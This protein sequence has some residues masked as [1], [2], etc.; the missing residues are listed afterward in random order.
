[1]SKSRKKL[2]DRVLATTLSMSLA[3]CFTTLSVLA[4][5]EQATVQGEIKDVSEE[6]PAE[7][8][9]EENPQEK[10]APKREEFNI[11]INV[12]EDMKNKVKI[13][14][15]EQE[16]AEITAKPE[17]EIMLDVSVLSDENQLYRIGSVKIGENP[18]FEDDVNGKESYQGKFKL[19]QEMIDTADD[20]GNIEISVEIIQVYKVNFTFDASMGKIVQTDNETQEVGTVIMNQD[21]NYSFTAIPEENYRVA[22]IV[23]DEISETY[24]E[25]SNRVT[26]ELDPNQNH[27]VTVIFALNQY[28]ISVDETPQNGFLKISSD[29]V[30]YK[31]T[32]GVV[33]TPALNYYISNITVNGENVKNFDVNNNILRIDNITED[34]VI[35]VDFVKC[36]DT[37]EEDFSVNLDNLLSVDETEYVFSKGK[38][39]VFTTEKAGIRLIGENKKVLYGDKNTQ[40]ISLDSEATITS[41]ELYYADSEYTKE[42]WHTVSFNKKISFYDGTEPEI[43]LPELPEF[44]NCYKSDVKLSLNIPIPEN[45]P[46]VDKIEYCINDEEYITLEDAEQRKITVSAEDYDRETVTVNVKVTDV[47]GHITEGI[48]KEFTI[49]SVVPTVEVSVDGKLADGAN[50]G[51]YREE[52]TAT[53]TI[54]DWEKTLNEDSDIFKII[55]DNKEL[56]KGEKDNMISWSSDGDVLTAKILFSENGEYDWNILYTNLAGMHNTGVLSEN[57]DS[58]YQFIID[59]NEMPTGKIKADEKVWNTIAEVLSFGIFKKSSIKISI[60]EI[61]DNISGIK[62]VSYFVDLQG[63]NMAD[64]IGEAKTFDSLEALYKAENSPFE[65]YED[66]FEITANAK[67][68]VYARIMDNAGNIIYISSDGL[69]VDNCPP[70]VISIETDNG[71]FNERTGSRIINGEAVFSVSVQDIIPEDK[72]FSGISRVYYVVKK[73]DTQIGKEH[74]LYRWSSETE[75]SLRDNWSGTFIFNPSEYAEYNQDN[76]CIEVIVEDNSGNSYSQDYSLSVNTDKL[77]ASVSFDEKKDVYNNNR[78]SSNYFTS[79]TAIVTISNDR[80]TAFNEESVNDAIIKA[81]SAVD[82]SG[83]PVAEQQEDLITISKWETSADNT[84]TATVEFNYDGNYTWA[85]TVYTNDAGNP[86]SLLDTESLSF[87][88]DSTNPTGTVTVNDNALNSIMNVLTFGWWTSKSYTVSLDYNDEISHVYAYYYISRNGNTLDDKALENLKNTEWKKYSKPVEIKDENA[89]TI[90]FKVIDGAGNYI[91]VSSDE[92][93]IIDKSAPLIDIFAEKAYTELN[94]RIVYNKSYEDGISVTV[95]ANESSPSAGLKL[96]KYWIE[97][98]GKIAEDS[99]V[100]LFEM[101]ENDSLRY[102]LS[103]KKIVIDPKKYNSSNVV[104]KVQ[105]VDNVNNEDTKSLLLDIDTTEPEIS[106][107][108]NNNDD[109][110]GNACFNSKRA[111][112]VIITER[113]NH[114]DETAA[115]KGISITAVDAEGQNVNNAYTISNWITEK[116]STPDEYRHIATITYWKDAEYTFD[117]SYT[118]MAGNKNNG[119]DVG[120]SVAPYSFTID[121]TAPQG[122]LYVK[123]LG[124]RLE[125]WNETINKY[126]SG[127]VDFDIFKKYPLE[128]GIIGVDELSGVKE[129]A[130]L[131]Q[132]YAENL[133]NIKESQLKYDALEEIYHAEES[134]FIELKTGEK[135]KVYPDKKAVVYARIMDN[136]GNITYIGSDGFI[137]DNHE[138]ELISMTSDKEDGKKIQNRPVTFFVEVSDIIAENQAFSGISRIYYNVYDKDN[139]IITDETL[140]QWSESEGKLRDSWSGNFT[141]DAKTAQKY[142]E[143]DLRVV[144]GVVDNAENEYTSDGENISIN[145]DELSANVTFEDT[146]NDNRLKDNHFTS[147]KATVTISNERDTSFDMKAAEQA[148]IDAVSAKAITDDDGNIWTEQPEDLITVKWNDYEENSNVRTAS[149]YFNYCG[150]YIWKNTKYTNIAGNSVNILNVDYL[151]FTIDTVKPTGSITIKENAESTENT[152]DTLLEVLTFGLYSKKQYYISAE[153]DDFTSDTKIEYYINHDNI[154]HN[155]YDFLDSVSE[156]QKYSGEFEIASQDKYVIYLRITDGAGNYI[157]ICSDGHIID[158]KEPDITLSP[159]APAVTI[160]EKPVYNGKYADGVSVTVVATENETYAG[161]KSVEYWVTSDGNE[162]QRETLFSFENSSPEYSE[163]VSN[164]ED[165]IIVDT[166]LNNS[167]DVVLYVKCLDNAGNEKTA[168]IAMDIDMTAPEISVSYDNNQDNNGNTYFDTVRTATVAITERTNHFDTKSATE[169]IKITAVD[170]DGNPVENAFMISEWNTTAGITPDEDIHI[171][172]ISYRADANYTFAISYTDMAHNQNTPTDTGDSVAPYKFTV[173]TT[174]PT[175]TVTAFS[176]EGRELTWDTLADNLKFGFWS[177]T[178]INV[179]GTSADRTSPIASV[180]YYKVSSRNAGDATIPLTESDLNDVKSWQTFDERNGINVQPNEQFV[181]YLKIMDMAGN[182]QYIST[183][184]LIVDSEAPHEEFTAPEINITPEQKESGI[185]NGNVPIE[186]RVE[187]PLTG[188]TYSGLRTISYRVLNMG[189]ETQSGTLYSFENELPLQNELLQTW[190]GEITVDSNLNNSNDVVIEVYAEDNAYNSSSNEISIKIDVT[191]PTIQVSYDNN[192]SNGELFKDY[193]TARIAV[194]ERNFSEEYV[195][196][197]INNQPYN[198]NGWTSSGG[199]GNGDDTIWTAN[200]PFTADGDYTFSINCTDLASNPSSEVDYGVSAYPTEFTI[201]ATK[202]EISVEFIEEE[203]TN[204]DNYYQNPRIAQITIDELHFDNVMATEGVKCSV[205][206]DVHDDS[207][208]TPVV[209]SEWT[210]IPDTNKYVATMQMQ[211]D[212]KYNLDVKYTDMAGNAGDSYQT[213]FY[214]DNTAPELSVSVNDS[215]K[216]GAYSGE[217]KSVIRYDDTNF[218]DEQVEISMSGVNVEVTDCKISDEELIFT[219]KNRAGDSI[220]WKGEFKDVLEE[221]SSKLYG[222]ELTFEN[223]PEGKNLKDFDDIYTLKVSLTDK[224]GRTSTQEL[225]FSVNRFGS[226][227]DITQIKDILGTYSQE[228]PEIIVSEVN[229]DELKEHSVTLFKNNETITLKKDSDYT[230]KINGEANEWH[231]Y[232]YTIPSENFAED[233]IY[234]ITL[235]SVDK[236]D[237]ISE[238]TLDTKDSAISF[239]VDNTPPKAI[240]ANLEDDATYAE[241]SRKIIMTAD[242]NLLLSDVAVYLDNSSEALKKWNEN[243]IAQILR[244]ENAEGKEFDF[245]ISGDSTK[246]HTLKIICTDKAGNETVLEYAGFYITTNMW[247]R[248][249]NNKPLLFGSFAGIL[250]FAGG[251]IFIVTRKRKNS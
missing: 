126:N 106:V 60:D 194:T 216:R 107:S 85:N 91:Y 109:S 137:A 97:V 70:E 188:G 198:A 22:E 7:S 49:N 95:S 113:N 182:T 202:P 78:L 190:T 233:G 47:D 81:I 164:F 84:H 29:V 217:I 144:I 82:K 62:E 238:N 52:R 94:G 98:D 8:E 80:D 20:D 111:A 169:N 206:T 66:T 172:T 6:L 199:A 68:V 45:Y 67:A 155:D 56:T 134:P 209:L 191:A 83:K 44:L 51:C 147:R 140:Y 248:Y 174:K 142:N 79:R 19:T 128:F 234:S 88:I 178:N 17:D 166:E 58:I 189:M 41:I 208:N 46:Q 173:D 63:E 153:A 31:N 16:S 211:E 102:E 76:I 156:W 92:N 86:V 112:T 99:E 197:L 145:V 165:N 35:H 230:V 246:A 162:T 249:I 123:W 203:N 36:S 21:D 71:I 89:Y 104:L 105:A 163:L 43:I 222:R 28:R 1:M 226:T 204:V 228:S 65:V 229:P 64:I 181:I 139:K 24:S 27:N 192:T 2:T 4:E 48:S 53:V 57:G 175:G 154:P 26:K 250:I 251:I 18:L 200:V 242:D 13:L 220:E 184:G 74:E 61:S 221:G 159:E 103:D 131:V 185:Y 160:D 72:A 223:F 108:Y 231:E 235:H 179:S 183:N 54:N 10:P 125:E 75:N 77:T 15:N 215:E 120:K 101:N 40:F 130:Y 39:A 214:V 193:R 195:T 127:F 187:D 14:L 93:L 176:A 3:T 114:F 122:N 100:T 161:L 30:D 167:S 25:N 129:I 224:S 247:I 213:E 121:T 171:A 23:I 11:H 227:Y 150:N 148:I 149:V 50:D 157:Y 151:E 141:L 110:D 55:K 12:S 132:N 136:A 33:I 212:A 90:Y 119:V 243:E 118:D 241:N 168:S 5:T 225:V 177:N 152:W 133:S 38:E 244:N 237:N 158:K 9:T 207:K 116:G 146:Y 201:D 117:I 239:A 180:Q 96:V 37:N 32:V 73:D 143:D 210:H 196:I 34:K 124:E 138:P 135:F 59:N 236:A 205:T 219:L 42:K 245:E 186:I 232:V 115:I 170:I 87:I 240:I 69:I 218:D